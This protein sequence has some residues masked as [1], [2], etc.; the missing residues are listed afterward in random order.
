V[1]EG[2]L[3]KSVAWFWAWAAV[4]CAGAL[5]LVSLGLLALVPAAVAGVAMSRST[6]ARGSAFG[7]FTGAGIL[8][9]FVAYVQRAGPENG[10]LNPVPWLVIGG[11]FVIGGAVAHNLRGH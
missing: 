7:L 4:G 5:G 11:V 8:L 1:R 2:V 3:V 6:S 9:L 10:Y